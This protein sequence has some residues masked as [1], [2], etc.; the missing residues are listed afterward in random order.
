MPPLKLIISHNSDVAQ[1]QHTNNSGY[2]GD[3]WWR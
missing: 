1:Q 2:V 3:N